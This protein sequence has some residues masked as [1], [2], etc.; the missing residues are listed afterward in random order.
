MITRSPLRPHVCLQCQ[1][2]LSKR[3][4]PSKLQS[5]A[6]QTTPNSNAEAQTPQPSDVP[7]LK[8]HR[9]PAQDR[10]RPSINIR[11]GRQ[12]D[13]DLRTKLGDE[14]AAR[15]HGH[16]GRKLQ[17]KVEDLNTNS[18][19][20]TAKV[21]VLQDSK[22]NFYTHLNRMK[23]QEAKH[24]DIESLLIKE[25]GVVGV[26]EVNKSIDGLRKGQPP[27]T[28]QKLN[29]FVQ[30]LAEGFTYS[31]LLRY[32]DFAN[33]RAAE[34]R[35]EAVEETPDPKLVPSPHILN[36]TP[37]MPAVSEFSDHFDQDPLRGYY[38][39][40]H[41]SKQ[42]LAL[43]VVRECWHWELPEISEGLG[44]FEVQ[45]SRSDLDLLSSKIVSMFRFT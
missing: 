11:K 27:Q 20:D 2:N 24:V 17:E 34:A 40:S 7:Q 4:A 33:S 31:Q 8:I 25:K 42:K 43:K 30:T 3:F 32:L 29:E 12:R 26:E 39:P 28:W 1:R 6:F 44:Q 19:G 22:Y 41:T 13:V 5:A 36:V 23:D 35:A 45:M 16:R 9:V 21:I 15:L 38:M 37:W 14:S 10:R 18:L